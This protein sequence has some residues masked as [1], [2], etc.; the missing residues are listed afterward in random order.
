MQRPQRPLARAGLLALLASSVVVHHTQAFLLP[1]S[2]FALQQRA[3][4]AAAPAVSATTVVR[5]RAVGGAGEDGGDKTPAGQGGMMPDLERVMSPFPLGGDSEF[6]FQSEYP[7]QQAV[8]VGE[9]GRM[10]CGDGS[11]DR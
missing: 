2:P 3:A 11:A 8:R 4:P 9:H 6:E 1:V 7:D 10:A 5:R